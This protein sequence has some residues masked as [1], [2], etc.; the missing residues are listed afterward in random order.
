MA[1]ISVVMPAY[2]A[3]RT[4]G[5]AISS[6]LSQT[7]HDWELIVVDD[8]STDTTLAVIQALKIP[9]IK[10][11]S[12]PNAGVSMARKAAVAAAV[13]RYIALLD[14]D[15]LW[16]PQK[17]ER[18]L[19]YMEKKG[20]AFSF[21]GFCRFNGS[22]QVRVSVPKKIT[23]TDLLCSRPIANSS[24]M[25]DRQLI[26]ISWP[27]RSTGIHEDLLTWLQVLE[28]TDGYGLD[29]DLTKIRIGHVSRS[30]NKLKAALNVWRTYRFYGLDVSRTT[31]YFARYVVHAAVTRLWNRILGQRP[32][33]R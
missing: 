4:I 24:V 28:I 13:G 31:Y 3:E 20:A 6:V 32:N 5:A 17:L 2:N 21:T 10:V 25:L 1:L 26:K 16:A 27:E 23:R 15:D 8:G 30:S 12:Q 9:K 11:I 19:A 7:F 22:N 14:A 33:T 18:Q 29:E